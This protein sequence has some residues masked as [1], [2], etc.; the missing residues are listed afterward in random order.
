MTLLLKQQRAG[1]HQ[2]HYAGK[3]DQDRPSGSSQKEHRC[4][5]TRNANHE[6][7]V[8]VSNNAKTIPAKANANRIP[9][10]LR[11]VGR[12]MNSPSASDAISCNAS[13]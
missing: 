3:R 9:T 6:A 10:Q 8:T 2:R 13:A 7:R 11:F 1:D 5:D 4:R 12:Q